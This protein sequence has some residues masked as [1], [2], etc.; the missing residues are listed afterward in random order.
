MAGAFG[1]IKHLHDIKNFTFGE[2]KSLLRQFEDGKQIIYEKFDGQN[3]MI[4]IKNGEVRA[5][6][7]KPS[8]KDPYSLIQLNQL[9]SDSKQHIQ[10]SFS[11]AMLCLEDFL[12]QKNL[13]FF[14][15]G[16]VFLNL[17]IINPIARNLIDYG[18]DKRIIITGA[19]MTD[20]EGNIISN[21]DVN[22]VDIF[23]T[24][25]YNFE[26]WV[27][28]L[29]K[30]IE[31]N[32]NDEIDQSIAEINH[33]MEINGFND[34]NKI[35]DYLDN[36]IYKL[37]DNFTLTHSQKNNLKQRWVHGD[38]S[39]KMSHVNYGLSSS[40]IS[41]YEKTSL[42]LELILLE[43]EYV[44]IIQN[45]GNSLLQSIAESDERMNNVKP[46]ID[47]YQQSLLH[48]QKN[49][50]NVDK[51]LIF[52]KNMGGIGKLTNIEG[53]VFNYQD[54]LYKIVGLFQP[55]NQICGYYRYR[56]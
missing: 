9:F 25:A 55:I 53:I 11:E 20:G 21:L 37:I 34:S 45:F 17:E 16:K 1:S 33:F 22:S 31:Y 35:S 44:K 30:K 52:I 10:Q 39:I 7:N 15:N 4:T 56:K 12:F 13:D 32:I 2:L 47:L 36:C 42:P 3:L 27:V 8:L 23:D 48:V 46:I 14:N 19:V 50:F 54:K 43:N 51:H 41:M 29:Y 49:E 24:A 18:P 5:A 38:K 28:E 26:G 40:E 6:R